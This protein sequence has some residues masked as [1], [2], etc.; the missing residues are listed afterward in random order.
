MSWALRHNPLRRDTRHVTRAL[1]HVPTAAPPPGLSTSLRVLASR[2]RART[3]QRRT[4]QDLART[5]RDRIQLTIQNLMRP[6]AV[7]FA[8]GITSAIVLFAVWVAPTYPVAA[9]SSDTFDPPTMLTT[10]AAV[11]GHLA[12]FGGASQNIVVNVTVDQN[13]RFM[14][15]EVVDGKDMLTT[16]ELRSLENQLYLTSYEPATAFGKPRIGKVIVQFNFVEVKG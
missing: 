9:Q 2:E 12:P 4:W 10:E 5:W 6:L 11:K 1:R 7:P 3:A 13:G 8:S 16:A 15:Y 14:G